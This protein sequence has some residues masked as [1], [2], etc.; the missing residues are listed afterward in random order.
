MMDQ[1]LRNRNSL[2]QVEAL[3]N[4]GLG[5]LDKDD[6][7]EQGHKYLNESWRLLENMKTADLHHDRAYSILQRMTQCGAFKDKPDLITQLH[8]LAG[9]TLH[10]HSLICLPS[11]RRVSVL[12]NQNLVFVM[13]TFLFSFIYE[14]IL[15]GLRRMSPPPQRARADSG[16]PSIIESRRKVQESIPG[17][18]KEHE[19]DSSS[20]NVTRAPVSKIGT[21][22]EEYKMES[23]EEYKMKKESDMSNPEELEKIYRRLTAN[24]EIPQTYRELRRLPAGEAAQVVR[25]KM[26][27]SPVRSRQSTVPTANRTQRIRDSVS[28]PV[29]NILDRYVYF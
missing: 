4:L 28:D 15:I 3:L 27:L 18:Q 7:K 20:W 13:S 10:L 26:S 21:L 24:S 2:G 16:H 6:C 5:L 29:V 9:S 23:P 25:R 14:S 17:K 22:F 1:A 8:N 11:F 12:L 19:R